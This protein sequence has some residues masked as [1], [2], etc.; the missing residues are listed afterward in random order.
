MS[1]PMKISDFK[2]ERSKKLDE[3]Y[4]G[5]EV[6]LAG[7]MYAVFKKPT[8]GVLQ[9]F[10][11][12]TIDLMAS[13]MEAVVEEVVGED[14][15]ISYYDELGVRYITGEMQE[16]IHW[17]QGYNKAKSEARQRAKKLLGDRERTD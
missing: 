10:L 6:D 7:K 17:E 12:E 2:S 8:I 11:S 9:D 1:K 3:L 15:N 4:I 13:Q 16:S 5:M 14:S